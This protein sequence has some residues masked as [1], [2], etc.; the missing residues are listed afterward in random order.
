[1]KKDKE[2]LIKEIQGLETEISENYPHDE[3]VEKDI[4]LG[5]LKQLDEPEILSQKWIDGNKVERINDLRKMTLSDVVTVEKLQNLLVP[6]QDEPEQTDTNV[7]LLK[8]V[9]PQFVAD[10]IERQME[11]GYESAFI[12]MTRLRNNAPEKVK[13]W[14]DNN[15]DT[16]ARAWLDGYEVEKEKKYQVIIRD[17]EYIRLYLCKHGDNVIIGTN[18]NYIEKC[19]EVTYLTEQEIKDYDERYWAFAEE[20]TQ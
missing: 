15:P 20:I 8:P 16:Y 2:W 3:M 10:W 18:D 14:F 4:V 7:G 19:P 6:K 12:S 1:M 17:G 5:L 9:I 11:F 13:F